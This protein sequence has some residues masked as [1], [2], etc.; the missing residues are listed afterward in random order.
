MRQRVVK[1]LRP[2]DAISVENSAYPGT[3]DVNYV[4]GWIELKWVREWPAREGTAV[5]VKHFTPQQRVWLKRRWYRNGAA[6]LLLQVGRTWLLFDGA[7]ASQIVGLV[8]KRTLINRARRVWFSGLVD[9]EL[10]E[11][12]ISNQRPRRGF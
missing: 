12:L 10:E 7:T 5:P 11:W 1:A 2:L 8:D 4:E 6:W 3:P 9:K